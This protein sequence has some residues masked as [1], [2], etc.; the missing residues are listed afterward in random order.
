M[1]IKYIARRVNIE[2]LL[3]AMA[4]A[5]L[6]VRS[7][8]LNWNIKSVPVQIVGILYP[9]SKLHKYESIFLDFYN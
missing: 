4:A 6:S 1:W 7:V 9:D 5:V 3:K 8:G 2:V